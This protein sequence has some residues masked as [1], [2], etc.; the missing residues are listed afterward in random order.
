MPT[1]SGLSAFLGSGLAQICRQILFTRVKTLS[2]TNFIASG[3]IKREK[4]LLSIDVRRS[5][6]SMLKLPVILAKCTY[7]G[8]AVLIPK[9]ASLKVFSTT[10]FLST[11]PPSDVLQL[12]PETLTLCRASQK[13]IFF[14]CIFLKENAVGTSKVGK[15][16]LIRRRSARQY[17][18]TRKH[19]YNASEI[20]QHRR[21]NTCVIL[22]ASCIYSRLPI[23]LD[24][25]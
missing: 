12:F 24:Y 10:H 23:T 3:H 4:A 14:H 2:K 19:K 1:G 8:G 25:E 20:Q 11:F 9:V 21:G 18:G 6:T 22:T 7:C 17:N 15:Q 5:N 16:S 13:M